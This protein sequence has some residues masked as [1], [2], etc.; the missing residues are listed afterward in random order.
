MKNLEI[1][2][3][4]NKTGKT[5]FLKKQEKKLKDSNTVTLLLGVGQDIEK[6]IK[7][8][9]NGSGSNKKYTPIPDIIKFI[10][11][12]N[13]IELSNQKIELDDYYKNILTEAKNKYLKFEETLNNEVD[14]IFF[15]DSIKSLFSTDINNEDFDPRLNDIDF[16]KWSPIDQKD[17]EKYSSGTTVYSYFKLLLHLL[18]LSNNENDNKNDFHLFIDEPETFCHPELIDKIASDIYEISNIINVS[19]ATHSPIFLNRIIQ[20]KK[21]KLEIKYFFIQDDIKDGNYKEHINIKIFNEETKKLNSREWLKLVQC[22]FSTNIVFI[23]GLNDFLFLYDIF[24]EYQKNDFKDKYITIIDCESRTSIEK[25]AKIILSL[26]ID[27]KL[28]ILIFYDLDLVNSKGVGESANSFEQDTYYSRDNGKLVYKE[29]INIDSSF[30][31]SI[32]Q[33]PNLE[34]ELFEFQEKDNFKKNDNKIISKKELEKN[35]NISFILKNSTKEN[36]EKIINEKIKELKEWLKIEKNK[37][38]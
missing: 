17:I 37:T 30:I 21:S 32:I 33:K 19:V 12:F 16:I 31:K 11:K 35:M 13:K 24:Y 9:A 20:L 10:N 4:T 34:S 15:E 25:M 5:T 38:D 1:L 22:L 28:K 18:K 6:F 7:T 23:E 2:I 26:G 27:S 14:N 29:E 36:I 8:E 3:G